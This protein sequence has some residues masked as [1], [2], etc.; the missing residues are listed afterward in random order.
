MTSSAKS[1]LKSAIL[2]SIRD[3]LNTRGFDVKTSKATFVRTRDGV[4]EI[5]QLVILDRKP[6][7][8][9]QPNVAVRIERVEEIFHR[10]SGFDVKFQGATPTIGAAVG[11]LQAED[12]RACEFPIG[13][14][15]E[16][17]ALTRQILGTFDT[18]ALKYFERF[19]SLAAIDRELNDKP[20]ER[21]PNRGV[22]WLRCSSGIIVAKL[23]NRPNFAELEKYYNDKME[24]LSNGFYAPKFRSLVDSLRNI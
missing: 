16:I 19:S 8:V 20:C 13:S 21:T 17:P 1:T 9:L 5:F 15:G 18:F 11:V 24:K 6:G 23:V 7:W 10:S 3:A 22:P 2:Q 12:A 4:T 14:E